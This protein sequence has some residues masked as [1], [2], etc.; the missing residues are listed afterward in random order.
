MANKE[1]NEDVILEELE[2]DQPDIIDYEFKKLII[3]EG[4]EYK[5][6]N[7]NLEGLTGKDI[8]DVSNEL[9]AQG[10]VLG[11][12]ET[13]KNFLAALAARAANLPFEFMDYIPARDFSKITIEVQNFLL[14]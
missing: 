2:E 11:F 4:E 6:I 5:K 13:N 1:I 14:G 3:F 10:E 7:I 12:A 9:L 8:K